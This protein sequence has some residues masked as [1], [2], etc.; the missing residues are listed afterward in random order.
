MDAPIRLTTPDG[1]S[2]DM[3]LAGPPDGAPLV[4]FCGTPG[5]GLPNDA[6]V[7]L[8]AGRGMRYVSWSRPGYGSPPQILDELL[9]SPA[10]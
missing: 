2:L 3:Y 10:G 5:S 8:L 7:E 4:W 9:S 6:L 1:R